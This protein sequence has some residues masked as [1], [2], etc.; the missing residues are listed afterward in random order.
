MLRKRFNYLPYSMSML[1]RNEHWNEVESCSQLK[2]CRHLDVPPMLGFGN[3]S[4][5]HGR[6]IGQRLLREAGCTPS[7]CKVHSNIRAGV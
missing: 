6:K 7:V 4:L 2:E 1:A 5:A 3:G